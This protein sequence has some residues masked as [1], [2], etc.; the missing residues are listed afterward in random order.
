MDMANLGVKGARTQSAGTD[1]ALGAPL[2]KKCAI[3]AVG[4]RDDQR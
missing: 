3:L 2:I 4:G 1:W